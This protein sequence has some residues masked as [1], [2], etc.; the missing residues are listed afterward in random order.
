MPLLSELRACASTSASETAGRLRADARTWPR[1]LFAAWSFTSTFCAPM[2]GRLSDRIGR[3][4]VLLL[5]LVGS[6]VAN[7]GQAGWGG[8]SGRGA[9]R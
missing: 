9:Q 3:K 8:G 7:F 4:E 1:Y 2:L 5:S 6:G